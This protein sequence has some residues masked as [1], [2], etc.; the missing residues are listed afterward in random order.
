MRRDADRLRGS[1]RRHQRRHVEL[2]RL[3]PR[4]QYGLRVHVGRVYVC[5]AG[6]R[7]RGCVRQHDQ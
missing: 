1:V 6:E 2:R 3:R 5:C 4:M 7:V